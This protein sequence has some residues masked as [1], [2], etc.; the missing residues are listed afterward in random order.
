M[1]E[2]TRINRRFATDNQ[3]L[4]KVTFAA[5]EVDKKTIWN[6]VAGIVHFIHRSAH[7]RK[8]PNYKSL[9]EWEEYVCIKQS[10]VSCIKTHPV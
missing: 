7:P 9:R 10:L 8:T 3:S 2:M 5:K 1:C 6:L 4:Y